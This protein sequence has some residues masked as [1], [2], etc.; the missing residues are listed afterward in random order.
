MAQTVKAQ[1]DAAVRKVVV[2]IT[3]R[4]SSEPDMIYTARF[5]IHGVADLRTQEAIESVEGL[6]LSDLVKQFPDAERVMITNWR[7][8]EG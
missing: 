6:V 2:W 4:R 3:H 5:F 1:H 7:S 8:L